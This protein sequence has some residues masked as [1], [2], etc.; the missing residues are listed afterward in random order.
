L[1]QSETEPDKEP[2]SGAP[3]NSGCG[4]SPK[5]LIGARVRVGSNSSAS[6]LGG[7]EEAERERGAM[8][9][10]WGETMPKKRR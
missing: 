10:I 1:A 5:P 2:D 6:E 8:R 3:D 9:A 7:D 4:A